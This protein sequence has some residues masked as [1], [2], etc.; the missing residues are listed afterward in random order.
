M[1]GFIELQLQPVAEISFSSL[2]IKLHFSLTF[3]F[4][5]CFLRFEKKKLKF[6]LKESIY[7]FYKEKIPERK[8]N[9]IEIGSSSIFVNF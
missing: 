2:M 9:F 3:W 8:L 6:L 5:S 7:Q 1:L 4:S